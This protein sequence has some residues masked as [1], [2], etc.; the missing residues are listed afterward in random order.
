MRPPSPH[1]LSRNACTTGDIELRHQRNPDVKFDFVRKGRERLPFVFDI[2]ETL[3]PTAK[4]APLLS[5]LP[6]YCHLRALFTW[7]SRVRNHSTSA[8][9]C[10]LGRPR[11]RYNPKTGKGKMLQLWCLPQ[12]R[13]SGW[14]S[15]HLSDESAHDDESPVELEY[16]ESPSSEE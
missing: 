10:L 2:I 11:R 8:F 7:P 9:P 4:Y 16:V 13:R 14:T 1:H 12:E 3:L 15:V 5:P 6:L